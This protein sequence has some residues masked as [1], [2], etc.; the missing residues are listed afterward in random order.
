MDGIYNRQKVIQFL[1]GLSDAF[2]PMTNYMLKLDPL[3]LVIKAYSMVIKFE[4]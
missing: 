3:P 4:A 1:M 2:E